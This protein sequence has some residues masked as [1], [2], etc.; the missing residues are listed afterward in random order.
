MVPD[1]CVRD[2]LGP[3][4]KG[5]MLGGRRFKAHQ[6]LDFNLMA[7]RRTDGRGIKLNLFSSFVIKDD[8]PE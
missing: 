4:E 7:A 3:P 8:H 2:L 1:V 6:S 5:N